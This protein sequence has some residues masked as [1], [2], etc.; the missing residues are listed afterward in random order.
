MV[1]YHFMLSAESVQSLMSVSPL[2]AME[3]TWWFAGLAGA[4]VIAVWN[5]GASRSSSGGAGNPR[6]R[7]NV[8]LVKPIAQFRY[9]LAR[10]SPTSISSSWEAGIGG[11]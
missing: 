3:P 2:Y 7:Q 5:Y 11:V 9:L 1:F 4:I 10:D 8:S 6:S